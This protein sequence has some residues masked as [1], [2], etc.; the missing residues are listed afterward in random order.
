MRCRTVPG[1][2]FVELGGSL[3]QGG[4]LRFSREWF[5]DHKGLSLAGFSL[6][7]ELKLEFGKVDHLVLDIL[8]F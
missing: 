7:L 4:D 6:A 5:G 1:I 3:G 8:W 2:D